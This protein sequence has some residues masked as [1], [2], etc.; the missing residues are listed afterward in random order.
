[1]EEPPTDDGPPTETEPGDELSPEEEAP[2]PSS[3]GGGCG[4]SGQ[5][6]TG[7]LWLSAMA[8][9]GLWTRRREPAL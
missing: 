1:E 3:D 9:L 7:L 5:L 4:G 6:P 2:A 8:V